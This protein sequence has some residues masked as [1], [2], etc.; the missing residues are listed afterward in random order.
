MLQ[1][2]QQLRY[3]GVRLCVFRPAFAVLVR[4]RLVASFQRAVVL[5]LLGHNSPDK[6]TRPVTHKESIGID[7]MRREAEPAQCGV[8]GVGYI[9]Q[10]IQKRAVKVEKYGVKFDL[11]LS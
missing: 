6:S 11:L 7:R 3:A 10:R 9:G 5:M 2:G 4:Y 8:C 1:L